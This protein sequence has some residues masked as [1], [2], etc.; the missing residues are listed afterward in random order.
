M[1]ASGQFI[2]VARVGLGLQHFSISTWIEAGLAPRSVQTF[3]GY[4]SLAVT[5]NRY[6]H[7]FPSDDH[8]EARGAIAEE[9]M[10]LLTQTT[11]KRQKHN[12]LDFV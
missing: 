3:A 8:K 5:V 1:E 11:S 4:S 10:G 7:L 9:L 2:G 6:G 12:I